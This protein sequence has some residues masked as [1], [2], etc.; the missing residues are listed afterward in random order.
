MQGGRLTSADADLEPIRFEKADEVVKSFGRSVNTHVFLCAGKESTSSQGGS[1]KV[2]GTLDS[3]VYAHPKAGRA[4]AEA[5]RTELSNNCTTVSQLEY[6]SN[7]VLESVS[8][9]LASDTTQ[10]KSLTYAL[11]TATKEVEM[12]GT[13]LRMQRDSCL[14]GAHLGTPP[15]G[16]GRDRYWPE[17][18]MS[19]ADF[20]EM[21]KQV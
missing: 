11:E 14:P 10:P 20:T 6:L 7:C 3:F 4:L 13:L 2:P 17:K 15:G 1:W 9:L 8:K 12:K 19:R 5:V 16:R 18:Q 21:M